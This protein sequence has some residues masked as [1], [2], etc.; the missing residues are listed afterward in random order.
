[1]NKKTFVAALA[2]LAA[3]SGWAQTE[4]TDNVKEQVEYSS[5]E[6]QVET[7]QF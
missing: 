4:Q 6:Y 2:M 5:S 7:N 1:M 3:G